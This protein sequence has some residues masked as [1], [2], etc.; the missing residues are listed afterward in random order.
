MGGPM[1][2]DESDGG[3]YMDLARLWLTELVRPV[4]RDT[5]REGP[6]PV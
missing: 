2:V 1:A 6:L 4:G 3:M 5:G